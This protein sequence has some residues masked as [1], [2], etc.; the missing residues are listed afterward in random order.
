M[1]HKLVYF[2][3]ATKFLLPHYV[4]YSGER[5]SGFIKIVNCVWGVIFFTVIGD[6]NPVFHFSE[7]VRFSR[8]SKYKNRCKI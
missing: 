8:I 3:Q 1:Q 6:Y 7:S 4:D 2:L 5:K